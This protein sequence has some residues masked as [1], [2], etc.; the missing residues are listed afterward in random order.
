LINFEAALGAVKVA[1]QSDFGAAGAF[2]LARGVNHNTFVA[3]DIQK[4]FPGF[5]FLLIDPFQFECVKPDAAATALAHIQ[6]Q[7]S[8]L[9]LN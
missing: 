8:D 9:P 1:V 4:M 2:P 5:L 3:L 6:H 7:I